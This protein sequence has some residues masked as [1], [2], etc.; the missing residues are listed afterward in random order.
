[1]SAARPTAPTRRASGRPARRRNGWSPCRRCARSTPR[2]PDRSSP[3]PGRATRPTSAPRSSRRSARVWAW[4]MSRSSKRRWTTAARRSAAPPRSCWP[5]CPIRGSAPRMAER[6][7]ACLR[8][9]GKT[10]DRRAAEGVRPG[11]DPRRRRAEAAD[12]RR[13]AGLVAAPDRRRGAAGTGRDP[14]LPDRP[15]AWPSPRRTNGSTTSGSA[16]A[17]AAARHATA[18]GPTPLLRI[19]PGETLTTAAGPHPGAPGRPAPRPARRPDPGIPPH[20]NGTSA[21]GQPGLPVAPPRRDADGRGAGPRSRPRVRRS[22]RERE[23]RPRGRKRRDSDHD[24]LVIRSDGLGLLVRARPGRSRSTPRHRGLPIARGFLG[25][26]YRAV[27]RDPA[28]PPRDAPGVRPMSKARQVEVTPARATAAGD[29]PPTATADHR[30]P[31]ARRGPVRR[32]ARRRWRRAD[33]RTAPAALE[34]L[35]LGRL[36]VPAGRHARQRVR[37]SRPSTS[38]T[39]A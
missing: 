12:E 3:R 15:I 34:A 32:G 6:A 4:P 36:D 22:R 13:R 25:H 29:A 31:P 2:R 7:R 30:A 19:A 17:A 27:R 28:V 14:R 18:T 9:D 26:D 39:A 38:A 21:T 8:W 5:G 11:D 16:W 37:R 33:D 1:M 23:S 35:A 10:L 24:F 20:R